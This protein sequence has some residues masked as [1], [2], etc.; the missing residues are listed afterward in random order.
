MK[1]YVYESIVK[2]SESGE[3]YKMMCSDDFN[4]IIEDTKK[5]LWHAAFDSNK[6]LSAII[7]RHKKPVDCMNNLD[8]FR[9]LRG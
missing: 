6:P 2:F 8:L 4:E 9:K 7:Y 1:N 5:C 3:F